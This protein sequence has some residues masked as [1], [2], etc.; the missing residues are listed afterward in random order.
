MQACTVNHE[1][2]RMQCHFPSG[3]QRPQSPSNTM[4][5]GANPTSVPRGILIY[6]AV[7]PQQTWAALYMN[8][9]ESVNC[10]S[11]GLLCPVPMG[12]LELGPHRTQ[13]GLGRGYLHTK[14]HPS[15]SNYLATIHQCYRHERQT[16]RTDNGPIAK[17]EPFYKRS[18][19]KSPV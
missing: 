5:P 13:C 19:K 11:G 6:P 17:G 15:P 16:D 18:P 9:P 12:E 3:E 1:S 4:S 10:E 7:G 2:G 14:W 8:K